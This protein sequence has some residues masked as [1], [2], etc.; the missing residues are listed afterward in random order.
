VDLT[1]TDQLPDGSLHYRTWT[2]CECSLLF[3]RL[4]TVLGPAQ[5]ESV[6]PPDVVRATGEAVLGVPGAVHI[7]SEEG[8]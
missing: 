6:V 8:S 7:F 5:Q 3:Q 2:I 4:D 1:L